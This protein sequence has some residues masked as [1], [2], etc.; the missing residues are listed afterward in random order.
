VSYKAR[1]EMLCDTKVNRRRTIMW[2]EMGDK[3]GKQFKEGDAD[4]STQKL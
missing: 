3:G 2:N 4:Y 1:S